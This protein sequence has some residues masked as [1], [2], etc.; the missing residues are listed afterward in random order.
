M[1]N[2][3]IVKIA[4]FTV[5]TGLGVANVLKN[6]TVAR[7][8]NAAIEAQMK[9]DITAIHAARDHV[10]ENI[11]NSKYD[12]TGLAAALSDFEFYQIVSHESNVI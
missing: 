7:R 3:Q 5:V 4:A 12:D 8:E 11:S 1:Q 10:L 6:K 2:Q 9:A